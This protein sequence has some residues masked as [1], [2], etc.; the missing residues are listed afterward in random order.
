MTV[1]E[2]E[3]LH[4]VELRPAAFDKLRQL[5]SWF[6]DPARFWVTY[7]MP[8]MRRA[9]ITFPGG[10]ALGAAYAREHAELAPWQLSV[11]AHELHHVAQFKTWWGPWL[12][13]LLVTLLPLPALF[14][15]RWFVERRAYLDDVING[16]LTVDD[17]V[18]VLW[19][20]YGWCWP[21]PL[22]RR[23]F[24]DQLRRRFANSNNPGVGTRAT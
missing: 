11:L 21:R 9:R 8:W 5:I 4:D 6:N 14:S 1:A 12:I 16:R 22:M 19:N 17:A 13:P 3:R 18:A 7:R 2:F 23:W 10:L 15:G 20:S 24:V